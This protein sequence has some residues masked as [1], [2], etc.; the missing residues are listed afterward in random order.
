MKLEIE[1]QSD[2]IIVELKALENSLC[3]NNGRFV[4]APSF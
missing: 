2:I 4:F 3:A 1:I